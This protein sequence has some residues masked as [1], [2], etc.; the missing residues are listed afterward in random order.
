MQKFVLT[1]Y[2]LFFIKLHFEK[3]TTSF[4]VLSN[5]ELLNLTSGF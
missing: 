1:C 4:F 3:I 5:C 2:F